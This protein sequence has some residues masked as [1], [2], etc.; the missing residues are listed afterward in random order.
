MDLITFYEKKRN[1]AEAKNRKLLDGE[2]EVID[3]TEGYIFYVL[4]TSN[5]WHLEKCLDGRTHVLTER[6]WERIS[7]L[8]TSKAQIKVASILNGER[9]WR[10]ICG[11]H[12]N[13]TDSTKMIRVSLMNAHPVGRKERGRK[14]ANV[15]PDHLFLTSMGYIRADKLSPE[16][17]I[18]TGEDS[19]NDLQMQLIAGT[20]LGDASIEKKKPRFRFAHTDIEWTELK[21]RALATLGVTLRST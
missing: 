13:K 3:G 4:D 10:Q 12:R 21:A 1:E 15:T 11:W 6:G 20:L 2:E 14:G 16:S 18:C 7:S 8:V 17:Q 9:V 19:P 5:V